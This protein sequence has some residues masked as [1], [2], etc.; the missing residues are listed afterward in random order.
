VFGQEVKVKVW[1]PQK[2]DLEL[3]RYCELPQH[4][5]R[6]Q[7]GPA[8]EC[9]LPQV[10]QYTRRELGRDIMREIFEIFE[11]HW[12]DGNR[13]MVHVVTK[14]HLVNQYL[15][16]LK[17][18][19]HM[20]QVEMTLICLNE[21]TRR[22]FE[23]FAPS[24]LRRLRVIK[25]LS[26]AGVFVRIM[27]MPLLCDAE[28]ASRLKKVTFGAGAKGFKHKDLNYFDKT[29]LLRGVVAKSKSRKDVIDTSL[30]VESGEPVDGLNRPVL[31][32]N[33]KWS[34]F[35]DREMLLLR[36]GYRQLNNVDW[37]YLV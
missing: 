9:F 12:N 8:C 32:P 5:K 17:R 37:G 4:L 34:T 15:K 35:E 26:D 22:R 16:I 13:W 27:A 23:T 1:L 3:S 33:A 11:K 30:L 20:V 19:R 36:S 31:M 18:M 2:L 14:S 7:I 25:E 28:E 24:V 21:E 6:V 10:L 29:D